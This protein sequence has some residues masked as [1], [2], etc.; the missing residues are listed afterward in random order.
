MPRAFGKSRLGG[1][2]DRY[3]DEHDRLIDGNG[4]MR[5]AAE[6]VSISRPKA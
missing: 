3:N 4:A 5:H 6:Y 2:Q 1:A